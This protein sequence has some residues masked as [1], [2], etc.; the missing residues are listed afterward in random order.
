MGEGVGKTM[1]TNFYMAQLYIN[2]VTALKSYM[3]KLDPKLKY[4]D[5]RTI[6]CG[7]E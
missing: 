2:N 5:I 4:Y 3:N 6:S 1:A 7:S